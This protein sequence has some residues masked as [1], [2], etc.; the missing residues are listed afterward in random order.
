MGVLLCRG[1]S[2]FHKL[3]KDD[4]LEN[5]TACAQRKSVSH[6]SMNTAWSLLTWQKPWNTNM[7]FKSFL[8]KIEI[9]LKVLTAPQQHCCS[10]IE[11]STIRLGKR[12]PEKLE[13]LEHKVR[14]SWPP[15]LTLTETELKQISWEPS[16]SPVSVPSSCKFPF[17][18]VS[19]YC[20]CKMFSFYP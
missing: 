9:C 1:S 8:S 7:S 3:S 14:F 15:R 19:L 4:W 2:C 11:R 20:L 10:S 5:F 16:E 12:T 18:A 17:L 13:H 6:R